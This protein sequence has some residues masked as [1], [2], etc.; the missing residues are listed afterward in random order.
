MK[1]VV[2]TALCFAAVCALSG[3]LGSK[4]E[5]P[6][7]KNEVPAAVQQEPAKPAETTATATT[8]ETTAQQPV[9]AQVP[10]K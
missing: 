10:A 9:E 4:E 8:A 5:K 2:Y 1:K 6:V 3:C 7:A